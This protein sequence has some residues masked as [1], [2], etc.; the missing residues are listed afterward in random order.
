MLKK[1]DTIN[2][3][4]IIEK[5]NKT[6]ELNVKVKMNKYEI[7]ELSFLKDKKV[8]KG[9]NPILE[10]NN[11]FYAIKVTDIIA[12]SPKTLKEA[13]GIVISDYQNHLE[14]IWI[15][16]LTKKYNIK[17]NEDVIYNLSK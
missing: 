16:E 17:I 3:K 6:S 10:Q 9:I 1:N 8:I 11:K 2:S 13:R 5:I 12:S 14:K 4:H 15:S 7:D